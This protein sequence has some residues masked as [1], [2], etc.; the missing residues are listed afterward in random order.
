MKYA[1]PLLLTLLFFSCSNELKKEK[2]H[3]KEINPSSQQKEI[4]VESIKDLKGVWIMTNYLD[5]ILENKTIAKYRLQPATWSVIVL[6]FKNDSLYAHGSINDFGYD[7]SKGNLDSIADINTN[8]AGIYA[9]GYNNESGNIEMKSKGKNDTTIFIYQKREDLKFLVQNLDR[10][11]QTST[12][13]THYFNEKLIAGN[14]ILNSKE[15]NFSVDGKTNFLDYTSYNVK[16]Y[17]GTLH[18][19]NNL[20]VIMLKKENGDLDYWNW[21]FNDQQLILTKL[22]CD[23]KSTDTYEKT[24]EVIFLDK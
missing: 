2:E 24:K 11:H 7:I 9:L 13:F 3:K 8:L 6:H 5:S 15:I 16:N 4:D 23:F 22:F 20:D 10:I 17:F 18:P 12:N 1:L 14:Y 19:F 21:E